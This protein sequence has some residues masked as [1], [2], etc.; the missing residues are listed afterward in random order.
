MKNNKYSAVMNII[1][2]T[3]N[4]SKKDYF[5]IGI[6]GG[7]DSAVA[8]KMLINC[9]G[10]QKIKAYYLPIE[11]NPINKKD[12]SLI[13][14]NLDIK[15]ECIDLTKLFKKAVKTFKIHNKN[16]CYNLK[17]KLRFIYLSSLA[18]ENN[19]LIVSCL[20]YDEYYLGYFT[21][22]G[23]SLGDVYPLL[24]FSKSEIYELAQEFKLPAEI[25]NKTPSADLYWG[26]TDESELGIN[27]HDLDNYL[28]YQKV[29]SKVERKIK[30]WHKINSHKHTLQK[31]IIP[32]NN[33]R[34]N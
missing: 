30:T 16:N 24:N 4:D 28:Q 6:S 15:I 2:K 27:Y 3:F 1:K 32:Q 22:N 18:F 14:K 13:S 26:Q 25:I 23:D 7:I 8:L 31:F 19:A 20:N 10:K 34:K 12:V 29:P 17:P 33:L 21:K 5:V 11:S 9:F